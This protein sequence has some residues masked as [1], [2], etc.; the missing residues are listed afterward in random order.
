MRRSIVLGFIL[1]LI[2]SSLIMVKP[3]WAQTTPSIPANSTNVSPSSTPIRTPHSFQVNISPQN[4]QININQT[5]TFTS[6]I[7]NGTP[8]FSYHWYVQFAS[9]SNPIEEVATSQNFTF[10]PNSTGTY[11]F[12]FRVTDALGESTGQTIIPMSV[13]VTEYTTPSPSPSPTPTQTPSPTPSITL[14]PSIPEFQ[15]WIILPLLFVAII[16]FAIGKRL[17][18]E[19]A[20]ASLRSIHSEFFV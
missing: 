3:A 2:A 13:I 10:K 12:R 11:Y 20:G 16:L 1:V 17:N 14:S 18:V 5:V 15:S 19:N 9:F 6:S 7:I 4:S 8:P